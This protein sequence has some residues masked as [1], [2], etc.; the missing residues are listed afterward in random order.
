VTT[1]W[2][3]VLI[4]VLLIVDI[5]ITRRALRYSEKA[6]RLIQEQAAQVL[7]MRQPGED[8]KRNADPR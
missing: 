2:L 1:A 5:V 6:L 8:S 4:S 3:L 7:A